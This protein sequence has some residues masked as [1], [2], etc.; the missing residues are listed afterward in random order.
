MSFQGPSFRLSPILAPV[1]FSLSQTLV[2]D[3]LKAYSEAVSDAFGQ[4]VRYGVAQKVYV[5]ETRDGRQI[6]GKRYKETQRIQRINSPELARIH[7]S[8][9]ER[10]NLNLRMQNRRFT[11]KTNAF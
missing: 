7:T 4:D 1:A 8:Y 11:R 6:L 3:G 2:T 5:N 10:Q 9:I